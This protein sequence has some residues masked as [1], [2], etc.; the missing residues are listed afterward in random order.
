MNVECR[1]LTPKPVPSLKCPNS[2]LKN[3]QQNRITKTDLLSV[4]FVRLDTEGYERM[5][6]TKVGKIITYLYN[7]LCSEKE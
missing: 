3:G 1:D 5:E 7:R 2:E 4:Y 6:N